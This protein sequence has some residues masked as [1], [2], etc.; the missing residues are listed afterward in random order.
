MYEHK[1]ALNLPFYPAP[2]DAAES[3]SCDLNKINDNLPADEAQITCNELVRSERG[4]G[5]DDEYQPTP[6][7]DC[8]MYGA[9]A[10]G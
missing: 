8:C 6:D 1:P 7:C 4:D 5:D 2:T 10:A 3:C 9:T